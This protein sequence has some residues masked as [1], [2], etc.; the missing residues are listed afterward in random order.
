MR[1]IGQIVRLQVQ[2]SSLKQGDGKIRR[3]VPDPIRPVPA[4]LLTA[5]GVIGIDGDDRIV[6]VHNSEHPAS[7]NRGGEN[8]I[9]FGF[10]GHYAEMRE[11]FDEQLVDGVAGEN[12]LIA[13][14]GRLAESAFGGGCVIQTGDG[15]A[16]TLERIIWAP[17]CVEFT[18]FA[19]QFPEDQRP[20]RRVTEGLQTLSDGLRGFYAS[21]H[22]DPVR[23][24]VGDR[25]FIN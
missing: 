10:T 21:Y 23:I 5:R 18:R 9:S 8:G 3:Y 14:D 2:R 15:R 6:D 7:R 13:Y 4:L 19:L 24:A 17:P 25:V 16:A 22:G 20:D 12:I 1:E 11:V